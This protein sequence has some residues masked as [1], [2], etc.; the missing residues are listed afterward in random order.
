[1]PFSNQRQ[2]ISAVLG[3]TNTGKTYLAIERMLG[4][5]T[6]MI[7]FPLRL[8]ARENYDRVV[9]I[10]GSRN[11]ALV[12]GEEKIIPPSARYFL[13]TVESM[14]TDRLV[15]FVAIDEIQLCADRERGYF[16]TD[17]LMRV[18]G[19]S[20]TMFLGADIMRPIIKKLVPEAEFI[21]RPRFSQLT[22]SG[23]KKL[24]RIP[25]RSAIV[26]FT[27]N[28][29]Y[30]IAEQIRR[31]RGGAAIVLGALSPRTR[32]SQVA[33][34][35]A[36]DVDYLVATDAI[37]MGL[38]MDIKHVA[39]WRDRK[40]DGYCNRDLTV[41][42][43]AQIAGRAGRHMSDGT[44]GTLTGQSEFSPE[45]VEDI[46]EHRFERVRSV[47]WRNPNLSFHSLKSLLNDLERSPPVSVLKRTHDSGDH[48][49]LKSLSG[50]AAIV[51]KVAT[52]ERVELLW[53]VCQI[54]DFRKSMPEV[55]VRLLARI[56]HL[57]CGDKGRLPVDWVAAQLTQLERTDGDIDTLMARIAHTRTWTYIA[58]R[59]DWLN[60]STHWQERTRHAE[61][62]LSDALHEKLTQRFVDRRSAVLVRS[63]SKHNLSVNV[64]IDKGVYV[65]G[66]LVGHLDGLRFIP[67]PCA[68]GEARR[69]MAATA[70]RALAGE[71]QRRVNQLDIDPDEAFEITDD[72]FLRWRGASIAKL[73]PG[74]RISSP[75]V[76]VVASDLIT[77]ELRQKIEKR[78]R[79]FV[80]NLVLSTMEALFRL[81]QAG[82]EGPARGI[83]FQLH[84]G[85]GSVPR[86]NVRE[87]IVAIDT[88]DRKTLRQFGV[89]LGLETVY[90]P[91]LLKP[92]PM[93]L[94]AI[95]WCAAK[96]FNGSDPPMPGVVSVSR[97]NDVPDAYYAALGFCLVIDRAIR[98][99]IFDRVARR[100]F[101]LARKGP[102][103]MPGEVGAMLGLRAV[104]VKQVANLLGY[105]EI[106]TDGMFVRKTY[107]DSKRP[108]RHKKNNRS[109]RKQT[110]RKS[111][112]NNSPFSPLADLRL[113][114]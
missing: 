14:P 27:A 39:F 84:Q 31:L 92:K 21:A 35:Q 105:I 100:L 51:D 52:A 46:E 73:A 55:H 17:R 106:E 53:E 23:Q 91:S 108:R 74:H 98:V 25:R 22:F 81:D 62:Q 83:V 8:L 3:P 112:S 71:I 29:V 58:H 49:A 76:A 101:Q 111:N 102:F 40:F 50:N 93:R 57:L 18:R 61:D 30:E 64:D 36:G 94:R 104:Q 32:N 75:A 19:M 13:C 37:G 44:F 47:W 70:L 68:T 28:D 60:N 85:L 66:E 78:L 41:Q 26:A 6:G 69:L 45:V 1:M 4:Y 65:E 20:E 2:R 109:V 9:G 42:E 82:L 79:R 56:F 96:R 59:S 5:R 63:R 86:L 33:M 114:S 77:L 80:E 90:L 12:T 89:K 110:N 67:D 87:Q 15:E 107:R 16:F 10:V 34:Y 95:L 72:G 99:D 43:I 97:N 48:A 113:Q 24:T 103:K 54:P 88:A 38:N 11:V 7:G